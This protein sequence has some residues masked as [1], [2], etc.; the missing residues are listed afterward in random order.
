MLL[1]VSLPP[2]Y[3]HLEYILLYNNHDTI[4][5]KVKASLPSNEKFDLEV[6]TEKGEGVLVKSE[7]FG[8]RNANKPKFKRHKPN[9]FCKYCKKKGHLVDDYYSL[10]TKKGER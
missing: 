8:N 4:S 9:K 2:S 10:K 7:P 5:F 1:V 6:R 3:R